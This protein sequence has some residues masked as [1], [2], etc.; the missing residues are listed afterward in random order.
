[1]KTLFIILISTFL[2]GCDIDH[3]QVDSYEELKFSSNGERIYFT[4]R[5]ETG[6]SVNYQG[7]GMHSQMHYSRCVDC[8]GENREGG[9]RMYPKFWIVAPSLTAHALFDDHEGSGHGEHE[10]YTRESL[11]KAIQMGV[12]PDGHLLNDAMPRWNLKKKDMDNLVDYLSKGK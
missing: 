8:H 1:M 3:K 11:S 12:S 6:E 7:G 4:G 9:K 2:V 5:N 10:A